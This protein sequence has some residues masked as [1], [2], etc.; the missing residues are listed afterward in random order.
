[1]LVSSPSQRHAARTTATCF[2]NEAIT[3]AL[4]T[5]VWIAIGSTILPIVV[6][7]LAGYAFAWLDFP[8]RD[9]LFIGVI[10]LLVVPIQMA[11]IPIFSLYDRAAPLRHDRRA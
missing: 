3:S 8:G 9:W 4:V 6:A 1:M 2:A 7:A 11:L 10:A 5:T